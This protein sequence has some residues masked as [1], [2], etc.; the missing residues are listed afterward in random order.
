MR[1]ETE[2]L[3]KIKKLKKQRYNNQQIADIFGITRQRVYKILKDEGL[4][5]YIFTTV[6]LFNVYK[7]KQQEYNTTMKQTKKIIKIS[8]KKF[9]EEDTK[10]FAETLKLGGVINIHEEEKCLQ[11][12]KKL[13]KAYVQMDFKKFCSMKCMEKYYD[14]WEIMIHRMK[15]VEQRVKRLEEEGES[16]EYITPPKNN[17]LVKEKK[18][19]F[20]SK[21]KNIINIKP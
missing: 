19:S 10:E 17:G 15:A 3:K 16:V 5:K 12:P 1:K 14:K 18:V 13:P 20:W 6:M 8:A 9:T 7:C 21:F 11:C 4:T 2:R